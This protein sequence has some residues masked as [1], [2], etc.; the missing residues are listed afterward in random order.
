M[1]WLKKNGRMVY[2]DD[3][4]SE[5]VFEMLLAAAKEVELWQERKL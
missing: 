5:N 4:A 1:R 2:S 3:A